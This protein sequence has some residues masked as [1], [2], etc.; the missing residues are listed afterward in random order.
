MKIANIAPLQAW[1]IDLKS[2][3]MIKH[4]PKRTK[5]NAKW[6]VLQR[7]KEGRPLKQV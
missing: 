6:F 7:I 5:A 1:L 2:G 3:V 4:Q